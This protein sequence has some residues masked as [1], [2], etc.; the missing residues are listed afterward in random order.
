ML[1]AQF[2]Y[3]GAELAALI[4]KLVEVEPKFADQVVGVART[5]NPA[6]QDAIGAGLGDAS[7]KF[8]ALARLDWARDAAAHI[9]QAMAAADDRTRAA[10][11]A[12]T[13][14]DAKA[15]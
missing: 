15:P 9:R 11:I 2:P 1:V 3:G 12:A 5:A 14:A 6:Q 4:A 10:W 13:G 7:R 8:G